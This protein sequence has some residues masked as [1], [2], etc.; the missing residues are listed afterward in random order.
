MSM[1]GVLTIGSMLFYISYNYC[2]LF[3][4]SYNVITIIIYVITFVITLHKLDYVI[5]LHIILYAY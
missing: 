1:S 2:I 3:Y 4:I 5:T